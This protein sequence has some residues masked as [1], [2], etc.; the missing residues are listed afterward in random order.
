MW[1]KCES[2]E[3]RECIVILLAILLAYIQDTWKGSHSQT[4]HLVADTTVVYASYETKDP[5][6]SDS[7][8]I[9]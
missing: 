7:N 1:K 3:L 2:A 8:W 4:R 9:F 5:W 6:G